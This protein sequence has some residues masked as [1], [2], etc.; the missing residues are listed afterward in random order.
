MARRFAGS[1]STDRIDFGNEVYT[2]AR[3][4]SVWFYLDAVDTTDRRLWDWATAAVLV[5]NPRVNS[6]RFGISIGFTT[7]NGSWDIAV[8]STGAWINL[9]FTMAG[10]ADTDNPIVY[11]DGVSQTVTEST[12][13][14]GSYDS[15]SAALLIGNRAENDRAMDGALAE[16][17]RWNRVLT[18]G[19]IAT[20]AKGF[21]PLFITN[22]LIQYIPLIGKNSPETDYKAGTTGTVTGAVAD[23]HPRIIYPSSSQ[24]RRFTTA[25]GAATAVKDLIMAGMIAFPR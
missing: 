3:T 7:T 17:G 2:A 14:S 23:P 1:T 12:T 24:I 25:A 10:S 16:I 15:S 21:S 4:V 9:I 8:P 6:T 13:P 5:D 18:A 11:Y 19:E 20:L 22:G